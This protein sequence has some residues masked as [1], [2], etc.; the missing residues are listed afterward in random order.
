MEA[1][2]IYF[3]KTK[4][5]NPPRTGTSWRMCIVRGLEKTVGEIIGMISS[6]AAPKPKKIEFQRKGELYRERDQGEIELRNISWI[7]RCRGHSN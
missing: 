6:V 3:L 5:T 7:C 4:W 2:L 1:I